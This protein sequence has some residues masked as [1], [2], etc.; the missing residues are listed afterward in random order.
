MFRL[1]RRKGLFGLLLLSLFLAA[2]AEQSLTSS[3][4][5]ALPSDPGAFQEEFIPGETG[6]WVFES[7]DLGSTAI[8]NEQLVISVNSP[9]TIQFS[10]LTDPS[11]TD[12]LLEV[13]AWQRSG[14]SESSYGVLFR[15]QDNQQFY[16]FEVTGT[17]L[18]MIE[19]HNADGTWTRLI[20]EWAPTAALNKG[21][22]VPNRLKIIATGPEMAFY[23]NDILLTQINDDRYTG[24]IIG[25]DAGTFSGGAVQV[26]F[27]SL[28]VVGE[29]P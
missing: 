29:A 13:D 6:N 25:L 4:S 24:G 7:D 21:L 27:D 8:V 1:H 18:Y 28:S 15:M 10:A 17:G 2:C 26:S 12:F 19:R 16:R 3:G 23:V 9:N 14:S 22:N 5:G 11:F 20:P